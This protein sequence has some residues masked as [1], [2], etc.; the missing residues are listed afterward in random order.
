MYSGDEILMEIDVTN[1]NN[2][3]LPHYSIKTGLLLGTRYSVA[4]ALHISWIAAAVSS[5]APSR[6]NDTV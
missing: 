6:K 5:P 3:C 1:A 4:V 2:Q